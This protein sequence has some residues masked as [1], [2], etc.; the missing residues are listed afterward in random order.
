MHADF[1]QR[2]QHEKGHRLQTDAVVGEEEGGDGD[3][4]PDHRAP[5]AVGGAA[6]IEHSEGQEGE[7]ERFGEEPRM[8]AS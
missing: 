6:E 2:I 8:C 1:K 7:G 3:S 4:G 5:V